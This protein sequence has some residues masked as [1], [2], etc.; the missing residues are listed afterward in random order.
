MKFIGTR[1]ACMDQV[2]HIQDGNS[3]KNVHHLE[4]LLWSIHAIHVPLNFTPEHIK[5]AVHFAALHMLKTVTC[6][7]L[8][9]IFERKICVIAGTRTTDLRFSVLAP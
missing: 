2:V 7:S 3:L 1:V 6:V 8:M 5:I 4:T 9:I